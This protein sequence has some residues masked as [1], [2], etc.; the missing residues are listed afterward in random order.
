[1]AHVTDI[2]GKIR[3]LLAL[4]ESP[5]ENEAKAA[6][7]KARELMAKHKLTEAELGE[8]AK[9]EVVRKTTDITFSKRRNPWINRLLWVI[10]DNYCCKAFRSHRKRKQTQIAGFI[11]LENDVEICVEVFKYAVNCIEY[12]ILGVKEKNAGYSTAYIK[13]QCDSYGYG[14][15]RGILTAFEQQNTENKQEWGLVLVIP[16]EVK[17][18]AQDLGR[19][20]FKAQ[21]EQN[22]DPRTYKEGY[23]DGTK[24]DPSGRTGKNKIDEQSG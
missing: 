15:V 14:Y 18:A 23:A 11:G 6:L 10:G 1:M 8:A 20:M 12:G 2:K 22:I 13:R 16:Q 3:N 24:F 5:N 4:A 21:A 7:L 17:D 19:V 9:Q